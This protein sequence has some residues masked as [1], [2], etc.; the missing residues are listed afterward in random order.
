[1]NGPKVLELHGRLLYKVFEHYCHMEFSRSLTLGGHMGL[2]IV[3]QRNDA[4]SGFTQTLYF[5]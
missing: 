1:M 5:L 4:I 2:G 3:V